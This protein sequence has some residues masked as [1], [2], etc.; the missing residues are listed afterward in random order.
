[1]GDLARDLRI[2][3]V[4]VAVL[5]A[6]HAPGLQF[7]QRGPTRQVVVSL[8]AGCGLTGHGMAESQPDVVRAIIEAGAH[9]SFSVDLAATTPGLRSVVVG[10]SAGDPA[11]LWRRMYWGSLLYGRR[12]AALQA[13]SAIDIACHDLLGRYLG[14]PVATLLGGCFRKSVPAYASAVL[15]SDAGE[16]R[17]LAAHVAEEG[18][19]A[20]KLGWGAFRED[21]RVVI[22][23]VE[24]ARAA[25]PSDVRLILDLGYERPRSAPELLRLFAQLERFEP[26]WFEDVCHPDHLDTYARLAGRVH[27]PLAAGEAYA[28]IHPYLRLIDAGVDILQ[29]DL[30]RCG[31]FTVARDIAAAAEHSDR[32]VIP[33]AWMNDLLLAATLQLCTALPRDTYVEYSVAHGPLQQ[34]STKGIRMVA[35]HLQLPSEPG[36]GVAP[37]PELV[38]RHR[39]ATTRGHG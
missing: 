16:I 34:I 37:D 29:P 7:W 3:S 12:G 19:T 15:P 26:L 32:R 6:Q 30:S 8:R 27:V 24:R 39:I 10:E 2:E 9:E 22:D 20:L 18:F 28:T 14:V 4:D 36:L 21:D 13:M 38:R 1:M 31:G 17:E 35:G 5:E 23:L 11:P 25:L 33:H